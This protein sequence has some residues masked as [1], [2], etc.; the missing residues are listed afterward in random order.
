MDRS[1]G[2]EGFAAAFL[3]GRGDPATAGIG[4]TTVRA[5]ARTLLRRA[6]E[7]QTLNIKYSTRSHQSDG[8]SV[9][10]LRATKFHSSILIVF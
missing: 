4:V 2:Y 1:N 3:A 7:G 8:Y 10:F 5:W 9:G 6:G